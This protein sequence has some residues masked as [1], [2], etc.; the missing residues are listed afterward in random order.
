MTSSGTKS[1][2]FPFALGTLAGSLPERKDATMEHEPLTLTLEMRRLL[3]EITRCPTGPSGTKKVLELAD[4]LK[5]LMDRQD[6][7]RPKRGPQNVVMVEDQ[8]T[9]EAV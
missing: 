9:E 1:W 5:D 8:E 2:A 7:M 3:L 6:H 4:Q